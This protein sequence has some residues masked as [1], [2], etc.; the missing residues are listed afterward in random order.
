M[1]FHYL[2]KSF[3]SRKIIKKNI[4]HYFMKFKKL[5]NT[6]LE[7]SLICLGTMTWGVQNNQEEAFKQMDYALSQG[8]NFF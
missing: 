4:G 2:R 8:I 3:N 1:E 5:G 7:V 6:D